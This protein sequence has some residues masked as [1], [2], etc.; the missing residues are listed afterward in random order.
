MEWVRFL[1]SHGIEYRTRGPNV[2]KGEINICCPVCG[3]ADTGFHLGINLTGKGWACWRNRAHSG[4]S[5]TR[6]VQTLLH[7]SIDTAR[8]ITGEGAPMPTEYAQSVMT[9]NA[10]QVAAPVRRRLKMPPEFLSFDDRLPSSRPFVKY[11]RE[12]GFTRIES[13]SRDYGLRYASR[14]AYKGRVV[15]PVTFGGHLCT[16]TARTLYPSVGLRYRTLTQDPEKAK[17]EG[18]QPALGPIG[19]YLLWYD[20]LMTADADTICIVEGPF[21]ALK[22]NV[23]GTRHGVVATCFFTSQPTVRQIDLMRD[24]LPR[25]RRRVLLPDRNAEVMAMKTSQRIRAL[26]VKIKMLPKQ[27]DDPGEIKDEYT[28]LNLLT[29]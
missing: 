27:I 1:Q 19:D 4:K 11:L 5:N 21:D 15:F 17:L 7:C 20:D 26:E 29:E 6:L 13:L 23:L 8:G 22:V 2:R 3:G 28:L 14:G 10:V 18:S 16:W 24:L 25:F 12:R 9:M